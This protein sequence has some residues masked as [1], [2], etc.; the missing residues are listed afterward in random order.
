VCPGIGQTAA[1]PFSHRLALAFGHRGGI[2]AYRSPRTFHRAPRT[3]RSHLCP[4]RTET[5]DRADAYAVFTNAF[6]EAEGL[7]MKRQLKA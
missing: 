4:A 2:S 1:R 7:A 3:E 5:A 6:N